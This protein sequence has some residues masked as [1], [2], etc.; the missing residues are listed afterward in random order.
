MTN[1]NL[2]QRLA[3]A[4][5]RAAPNDL[6]GVLSRCEAQKGN[7]IPMT[8]TKK[9][10]LPRNL[11]AACLALVLAVGGGAVWQQTYAV[12]SIVSLDVNPSIELTVNRNEKILS[13]K[14]LNPEAA[15]VLSDMNGGAD[16]K[17][18][19]LDVATNAIIGALVRHGYL[20]SI[21][22]AIL[23]SVE[24][25]DQ[26]RAARLQQELTYTVDGVLKDRSSEATV[27]SQTIEKDASIEKQ[28]KE[29]SISTGKAALISR[30]MA[31]NDSLTF[32]DLSVLSV[33]ELKDLAETGAPGI[34]IG[35]EEAARQAMAYA[36]AA[37]SVSHWK[38]DAEL[39]DRPAHY[40]VELYTSAGDFEY[41]VDAYTGKILSGKADIFSGSK[42][43]T[44]PVTT[45][46]RIGG[47]KAFSIAQADFFTRYPDA[48]NSGDI[49]SHR[50]ELDEDDGRLHYDVKFYAGGYEADYEIDAET[51]AILD[52][53]V[54]HPHRDDDRNSPTD[55]QADIGSDA[56]KAAAFAHAGVTED[57]IT[58]L[59]IDHDND[60][61]RPEYEI[62][63][64]SGRLEYSYTVDARTGAI[65]EHEKDR[66][67]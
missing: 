63:F 37:D 39:D 5:S 2:E 1:R 60:D 65:L 58:D 24:D 50:V 53:D 16:L 21:S 48:K 29:N 40:E 18:A 59:E 31:L 20:D 41:D 3:D 8:T 34:P 42:E 38:T 17:G 49:S 54:D 13:C 43:P 32:D 45:P 7:V 28:A 22:S 62:E 56:A 47:E 19:K 27:L 44:P 51:G 66:D 64:K 46:E 26:T 14:G 23:I 61:G 25:R 11:I 33:E 67:D 6:Q 35:K 30:I 10:R 4:I 55:M 52:R 9:N 57:S 36:G 15:A 12:A